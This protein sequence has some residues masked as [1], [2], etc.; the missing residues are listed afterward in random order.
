[1]LLSQPVAFHPS[2]NQAAGRESL[3]Q[4]PAQLKTWSY[5]QLPATLELREVR[6][7]GT[8][9]GFRT[10]TIVVVT[11]LTNSDEMTSGE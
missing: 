4:M 1:V 2:A 10:Q 3:P 7:R 9:P 6:L 5:A 8:R 11:T